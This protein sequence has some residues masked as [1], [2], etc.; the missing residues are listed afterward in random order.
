MVFCIRWRNALSEHVVAHG[1]L[2]KGERGRG[3]LLGS[4]SPGNQLLCGHLWSSLV[5]MVNVK[6]LCLVF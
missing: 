2:R 1:N 6:G 5:L 4:P 3:E